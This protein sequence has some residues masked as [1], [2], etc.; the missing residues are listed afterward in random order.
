[1]R[2]NNENKNKR[3]L[4]NLI[5]RMRKIGYD[6]DRESCIVILTEGKR[7]LSLEKKIANKGFNLQYKSI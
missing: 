3:A 4:R 2:P 6:V 7:H 5:Y 1:M